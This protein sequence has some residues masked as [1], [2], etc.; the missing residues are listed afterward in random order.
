MMAAVLAV[1]VLAVASIAYGSTPIPLDEVAAVYPAVRLL[2]D[3]SRGALVRNNVLVTHDG[4]MLI[5][6][7]A[8]EIV[9]VDHNVAWQTGTGPLVQL[10]GVRYDLGLTKMGVVM[11]DYSQIGC[12]STVAPGTLIGKNCVAYALCMIDRGLYDDYTLFKNKA[13][14]GKIIEVTTVDPSRV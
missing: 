6:D 4:P 7:H 1:I 12:N 8:S 3:S 5:A 11:G 2:D 10:D 13:M 9:G 14:T